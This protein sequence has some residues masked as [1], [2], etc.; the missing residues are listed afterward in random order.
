MGSNSYEGFLALEN[1]ERFNS[2]ESSGFEK[3]Y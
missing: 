1:A 3:L 2:D